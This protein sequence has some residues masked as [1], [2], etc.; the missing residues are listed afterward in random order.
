MLKDR[1]RDNDVINHGGPMG[2][3]VGKMCELPRVKGGV[4]GS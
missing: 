1:V 3:V 2:G 4:D